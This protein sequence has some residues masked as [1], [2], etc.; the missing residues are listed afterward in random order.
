MKILIAL[1]GNAILKGSE[2]GTSEE[3]QANIIRTARQIARIIKRG[4]DA[5]ITHGNGPQIGDILL[6]YEIAREQLPVMPVHICGGESQ[7]MMGYMIAQA[8][9]NELRRAGAKKEAVCL[10]TQTVVNSRDP[11]FKN[12]SKPIGPFYEKAQA[13][14]LAR[15]Y[16]WKLIP[17]GEKYRRAVP[18]PVPLEIVEL[19]AIRKLV[20][21]GYAVVCAG[22]GGVPVIRRGSALQGIDAVVDKDFA[23]SLLARNLN[24]DLLMILTDVSHAFINFRKR[25]RMELHRIKVQEAE[26]YLAEGQFEEGTMKPK[27][28]A[29]IDFVKH[30]GKSAVITS[31]ENAEIALSGKACTIITR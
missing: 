2:R 26:K 31:L 9:T 12:P 29:A 4:H 6:R 8:I 28:Q 3:Q 21:S 25:G 11:N 5:I 20:S 19:E 22:G 13:Q 7:G 14:K 10:L 24:T 30:T 1:G 16:G 27:V 17:E 23:S 18:S 15:E